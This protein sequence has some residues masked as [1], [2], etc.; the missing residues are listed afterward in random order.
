LAHIKGSVKEKNMAVTTYIVDKDGNQID[1]SEATSIPSNR[2]FRGAWSL[3]GKVISEDITKA[4]ELFKD[5][6]REV[7]QPL[8]DAEDVVYM[9]ALEAGDSSA[10]T[11]SAEKKKSLRDAPAASAIDSATTIAKLKAAWDKT[12]LGDSPYS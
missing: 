8:L 11:A 5:K 3:S 10:Q 7:R 6:I 1:S 12:L 4:K 9:K 2:D